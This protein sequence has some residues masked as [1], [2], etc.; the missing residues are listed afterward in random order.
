MNQMEFRSYGNDA[1]ETTLAECMDKYGATSYSLF[2]S[3]C[4]AQPQRL[5]WLT[6]RKKSL[7][8]E[9][10]IF[11]PWGRQGVVFWRRLVCL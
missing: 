1:K 10:P 3:P 7:A 11:S 5:H 6:T 2:S 9:Q 8:W 4:W